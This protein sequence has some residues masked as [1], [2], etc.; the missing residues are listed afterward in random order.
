MLLIRKLEKYLFDF[1]RENEKNTRLPVSSKIY[2]AT[3]TYSEQ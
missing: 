3:E 2:K 1:W